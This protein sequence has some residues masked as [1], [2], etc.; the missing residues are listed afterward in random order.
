MSRSS[1]RPT[2]RSRS[3][4]GDLDPPSRPRAADSCC[5]TAPNAL[6]HAAPSN[7][8][9]LQLNELPDLGRKGAG[10]SLFDIMQEGDISD[11]RLPQFGFRSTYCVLHGEPRG[12]TARGKI[13]TPLKDRIGSEIQTH[14]PETVEIGVSIRARKRGRVARSAVRIP[15]FH[16]GDRRAC[17]FES[18]DRQAHRPATGV[19]ANA[20]HA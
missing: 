18:T 11:K 2:S 12:F 10:Q 17:R 5:R 15:R 3:L 8:R 4:I 9:D 13:I 7:R 1:R 19:A 14:Y 20:D 16:R 6:R